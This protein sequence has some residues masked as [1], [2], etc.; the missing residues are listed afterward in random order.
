M[1]SECCD[2]E[3]ENRESSKRRK[4]DFDGLELLMT[5]TKYEKELYLEVIKE[6]KE[7][8]ERCRNLTMFG[9]LFALGF[10]IVC[11]VNDEN[12]GSGIA[13]SCTL[14]EMQGENF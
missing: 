3:R 9:F 8:H 7:H 11:L 2:E 1:F 4:N 13:M 12:W 14:G 5:I 10:L 6:I